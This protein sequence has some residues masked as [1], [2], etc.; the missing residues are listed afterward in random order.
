MVCLY[1]GGETG[2][3]NSRPQKRTNTI[4]RRRQCTDCRALFTT[5][6]AALLAAAVA[7]AAPDGSITGFGRE[8]LL[9]S[10]YNSL[11]HRPSALQDAIALTDTVTSRLL[12]RGGSANLPTA[13]I[14]TAVVQTLQPFDAAAAVQY[15]AY[16]PLKPLKP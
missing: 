7:V 3:T 4:W 5:E 14:I 6:E 13:V 9:I 2:V 12:A 8:K 16:H 10:L 15:Q 11:R 1:C